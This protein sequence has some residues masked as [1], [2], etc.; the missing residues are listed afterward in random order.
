MWTRIGGI[1]GS[2]PESIRGQRQNAYHISFGSRG[3]INSNYTL[4]EDRE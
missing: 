1:M 2:V 4:R 3:T